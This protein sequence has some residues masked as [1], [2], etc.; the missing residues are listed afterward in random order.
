M[1]QFLYMVRPTRLT[2]LTD[3][4][5]E[6]EATILQRHLEYLQDLAA[7]NVVLLAGRTQNADETTFGIVIFQAE[8]EA[9]AA[10]IMDSDPAVR[11]GIMEAQLYPYSVAVLAPA[12]NEIF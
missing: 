2:M 4:P 1:K 7:D 8:S 11:H 3:R 10:A 12:I 5:T 6:E 9:A